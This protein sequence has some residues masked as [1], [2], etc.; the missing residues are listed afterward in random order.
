MP[1]LLA[2][3]AALRR[4]NCEPSALAK[5]SWGYFFTAA[6]FV[7]MMTACLHG[8]DMGLVSPACLT[9]CCV[10]LSVAELLLAP[11]SLSL[12]TQLAP[13]GNSARMV[14]PWLAATA[15]GNALTAV[16]G[17]RWGS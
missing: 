16:I 2:V 7:L 3:I 12:I 5:M 6:A 10:L 8:G 17:L 9:G 15:L 4:R 1:P 13:P 11:M 14:G